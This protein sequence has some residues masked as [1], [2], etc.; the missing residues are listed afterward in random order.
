MIILT[1]KQNTSNK[2]I[3][4]DVVKVHDHDIQRA[5]PDFLPGHVETEVLIEHWVQGA[6]EDGGLALLYPLVPELKP[7]LHVRV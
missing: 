1:S 3:A 5:L 7:N 6:L 2:L 4:T